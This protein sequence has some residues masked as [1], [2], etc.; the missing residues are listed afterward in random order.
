MDRQG[1]ILAA[2]ERY[3]VALA[4]HR[5]AGEDVR[6]AKAAMDSA[7]SIKENTSEEVHAAANELAQAAIA[8]DEA[9]QIHPLP[10]DP[11]A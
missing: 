10:N 4:A 11:H 2:A 8:V 5:N 6:R 7:V 1:K 3:R 9:A